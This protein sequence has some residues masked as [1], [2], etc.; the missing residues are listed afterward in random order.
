MKSLRMKLMVSIG[1]LITII[2]ISQGFISLQLSKNAL[3]GQ[4]KELIVLQAADTAEMVQEIENNIQT[5]EK[6]ML[7]SYDLNIKNQVENAKSILQHYYK[8]QTTGALSEGEAKSR[9]KETLRNVRY[10]ENG[11]FW[12]D[13]TAYQ[14][15][16]L[17]PTPEKEGMD[18]ST[19]QDVKGK[20]MVKEMV[21]GAVQKGE[22]YVDYYFPKPGE[23]E[24]SQKRGYVQLFE[25]WQ[26]VIGT[27]NYVDDIEKHVSKYRT[28]LENVL[29]KKI[30]ELSKQMTI[31]V[32]DDSGVLLYY[33]KPDLVG[34]RLELKDTGT[35]EDVIG[36]ILSIKDDFIDYAITDPELQKNVEKIGY[37][38]YDQENNRYIVISMDKDKVFAEVTAMSRYLIGLLIGAVMISLLAGF[39]LAGSFTRP[40]LRLKNI[41]EKVSKGDLTSTVAVNSEDEIGT[42]GQ[43]F[44]EMVRNLRTL[45]QESGATAEVVENA[46]QLVSEMVIQTTHAVEQVSAA[47]EEIAA[48]STEQ[49]QLTEE[50]VEK[51]GALDEAAKQIEKETEVM[52]HVSLEM[53]KKSA[54]G[55]KI[56]LELSQKQGLSN[57]AIGKIDKAINTLSQQVNSINQ[58]TTVISQI[59]E[60]TNLLALNAAIEAARAGEQ[61]R[62]FAVVAEEIRKLAEQSTK[63]AKEIEEIIDAVAMD[64]KQTIQAVQETMHIFKEQDEAVDTTQRIFGEFRNHVASSIEKI[65]SVYDKMKD[66]NRMKELVMK[67]MNK[68]A[69]VTEQTAAATQQVS[70]SVEEQNATM[71]EINNHVQELSHKASSLSKSMDK[72]TL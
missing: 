37:V 46:T 66:L 70:A 40:I 69:E 5:T 38:K 16:L 12:I 51:V 32:M 59:S 44:N 2:L 47:I 1:V 31:A 58:F 34:T 67:N 21:D 26:W 63:A 25:P 43:A 48:G 29:T 30:E 18:R 62:G 64:T 68:I 7:D 6:E 15:V 35:G 8:L 28:E 52:N 53:E 19:L 50:G 61:G 11:Y 42:L 13:S 22:I 56:I 9:A 71:Q 55:E 65:Q 27:G 54:E 10:G 60:Q 17:P 4:V 20:M 41:S 33:S 14:L 39:F 23:T 45:I 3:E 72:F 49:A 24:A 57:N 36:K